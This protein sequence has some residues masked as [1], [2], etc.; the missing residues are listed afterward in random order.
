MSDSS[1][2]TTT[3][4]FGAYD[5]PVVQ[6]IVNLCRRRRRRQ[7]LVVP[8]SSTTGPAVAW[9]GIDRSIAPTTPQAPSSREMDDIT[10][11]EIDDAT[12]NHRK[13]YM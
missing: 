8:L 5:H 2:P 13:L 11:E 1:P 3:L 6:F 10:I 4:S 7:Q 9:G 12:E